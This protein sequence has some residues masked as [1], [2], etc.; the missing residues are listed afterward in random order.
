[1][2][3]TCP[4]DLDTVRL[5]HEIRAIYARAATKRSSEFHFD[6]GPSIRRDTDLWIG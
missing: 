5:R 4:I 3:I 2:A 6:R 1:M